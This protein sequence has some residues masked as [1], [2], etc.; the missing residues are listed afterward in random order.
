M[1]GAQI[2]ELLQ[3]VAPRCSRAPSSPPASATR[4]S[5]TRMRCPARNPTPGAP[6]TSTVYNKATARLGAAGPDQ[7]LP[8][9]ARTS[10]W[11]LPGRTA[12]RPSST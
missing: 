8:A 11:P 4:S 6:T 3:P 7:D 1:T 9:S 2:L 5:A 10:S 12:S